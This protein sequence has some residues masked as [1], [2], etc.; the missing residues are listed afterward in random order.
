VTPQSFGKQLRRLREGRRVT[1]EQVA[2]QS[3]VSI[4]LLKSLEEGG[5]AGWPGGIYSRGYVR[6]YAVAIG[7]NPEDVVTAFVECYPAFAPEAAPEKAPE[8]VPEAPRTPIDKIK[9]MF[10]GLFR[11]PA[12][13]P[14][15]LE[16]LA[17]ALEESFPHRP[18]RQ[19]PQPDEPVV[20]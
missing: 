15:G 14:S 16:Q 7:V 6:S 4:A 2:A 3:K 5:C 13:T 19:R 17:R 12:A 8:A 9:S 18:Q 1:L 20:E 10:G 11:A